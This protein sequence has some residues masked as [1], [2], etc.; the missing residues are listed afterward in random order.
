LVNNHEIEKSEKIIDFSALE[1]HD[2]VLVQKYCDLFIGVSGDV[3]HMLKDESCDKIPQFVITKDFFSS[4]FNYSLAPMEIFIQ[5]NEGFIRSISN[6]VKK[7]DHC[8]MDNFLEKLTNFIKNINIYHYSELKRIPILYEKAL[9]YVFEKKMVEDSGLWLEFGV[10]NGG[11]LN[12]ISKYTSNLVFGFDSFE[13]LNNE[14]DRI[15]MNGVTYPKGAFSLGGNMP[16][17]N[18]NVVL[19]KGWFSDTLPEFMNNHD[20]KIMFMHIDSDIYESAVDILNC[21]KR[22]IAN[23][24]IIVFDELVG[25]KNFEN[26]EWKA[27]WEFVTN[28]NITFEWIGGNDG[29]FIKRDYTDETLL[30]EY[31]KK[32]GENV[33]PSCEN[34]AIRI[35]NNPI[36]EEK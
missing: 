6:V 20:E 27:L 4:V 13:G 1:L 2:F 26:N 32:E 18:E 17:M 22:K 8:N 3:T 21:T 31:G 34:V 11:T 33:S 14:W 36:F 24:C 23:G 12:R 10:F 5:N 19:I 15:E 16:K 29:G 9:N 30:F 25:Y 28:N 35:L 7:T